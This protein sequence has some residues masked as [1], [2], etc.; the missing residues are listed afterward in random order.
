MPEAVENCK[1]QEEAE[2]IMI[3]ALSMFTAYLIGAFP[4][5]YLLGR[6]FKKVDIRQI[7]SGNVGG[8]NM[9]RAAGILPGLLTVLLDLAKGAVAV[10]LALSLSGE[11]TVVLISSGLV[12]LGHN[13]SIFLSFKGGKGLATS[14]GVFLVLSPDIILYIILLALILSLILKD[15]NTAFGSATVGIPIVLYFQHQQWGW[16]LFGLAIAAVIISKHLNDF[17]AYSQRRR[18]PR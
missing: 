10:N 13:Y 4:T 17:Q 6:L 1:Y 8:M 16:V 12:V 9:Y 11:L 15:I 7:G 18:E 14:L 5:A 3:E 2:T